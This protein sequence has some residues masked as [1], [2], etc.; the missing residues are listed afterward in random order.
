MAGPARRLGAGGGREQR[1]ATHAS[2]RRSG[3]ATA[4]ARRMSKGGECTLRR[5]VGRR[6]AALER[7]RPVTARWA[8]AGA[9]VTGSSQ[10]GHGLL[11]SRG[12]PRESSDRRRAAAARPATA[13]HGGMSAGQCSAHRTGRRETPPRS[14]STLSAGSCRVVRVP[15]RQESAV[16]HGRGADRGG[17]GRAVHADRLRPRP[18]RARRVAFGGLPAG[19]AAGVDQLGRVARVAD[20][21]GERRRVRLLPPAS[22]RAVDN[23]RLQEVGGAGGVR[24]GRSGRSWSASRRAHPR[25]RRA[26]ARRTWLPELARLL[27][28]GNSLA[29]ALP[30]VAARVAA[31]LGLTRPRSRCARCRATSARSPS[32]CVTARHDRDAAGGSDPRRERAPAAGAGRALAGG[33][34]ECRTGAR[35]TDGGSRRCGRPALRGQR[36]DRPAALGLARPAARRSSAISAAAEA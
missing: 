32:R 6:A 26:A 18:G 10:P 21:G 31:T 12:G 34:A 36:Q 30:T 8:D 19:G 15:D 20:G 22:G 23:Q 17:A 5:L 3:R 35:A 25:R 14:S 1:T 13:A 7:N 4:V 29:E 27:L 2:A 9:P 16:T 11:T 28:S 33:G 24:G